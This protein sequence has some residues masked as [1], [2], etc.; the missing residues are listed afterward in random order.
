MANT[1]VASGSNKSRWRIRLEPYFFERRTPNAER[2]TPN[3]E[4][5]TPNAERRTPNAERR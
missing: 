5:R 2:R 3:A 1:A 4:R